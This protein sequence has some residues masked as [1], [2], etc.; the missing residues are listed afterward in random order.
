ME[1]LIAL[2]VEVIAALFAGLGSLAHVMTAVVISIG[3]LLGDVLSVALAAACA[4]I[5]RRR[6]T[7]PWSSKA[8]VSPPPPP[9]RWRLWHRRIL[10]V[11]AGLA[12][13]VLM[14]AM[15]LVTVFPAA[16]LAWG[17]HRVERRTGMTIAYGAAECS[18]WHGTATLHQIH[19]V[20]PPGAKIACDLTIATCALDL[21]L[22]QLIWNHDF[23]ADQVSVSAVRGSVVI[24]GDHPPQQPSNHA[25]ASGPTQGDGTNANAPRRFSIAHLALSDVSVDATLRHRGRSTQGTLVIATWDV[26][27]L[28]RDHALFDL[29]MCAQGNGSVCGAPFAITSAPVGQGQRT[30]WQVTGLPVDLLDASFGGPFDW[31]SGGRIDV[32]VDNAWNLAA[33][34]Y[35]IMDWRLSGN[36]LTLVDPDGLSAL[37]AR[38]VAV[39]APYLARSGGRLDLGFRLNV[40]PDNFTGALSFDAAGLSDLMTPIIIEELAHRLGWTTDQVRAVGGT[41][42][43]V[44]K[45]ILDHWRKAHEHPQP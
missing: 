15:L 27:P 21:H 4:R 13:A 28:D 29:V 34:K 2:L 5:G 20:T 37:N 14:V 44:G 16:V 6:P 35:L 38:L 18:F 23:L 1:A 39:L 33:P 9:S 3:V 10:I 31:V 32:D 24:D 22:R 17:I 43:D 8:P 11:S 25:D 45:A 26:A 41:A 30:Q 40:D 12:A 36:G 19:L 42:V 7:A